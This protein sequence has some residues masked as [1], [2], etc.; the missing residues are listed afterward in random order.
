MSGI[1]AGQRHLSDIETGLHTGFPV[2]RKAKVEAVSE[3]VFAER[4]L[5]LRT[6][7]DKYKEILVINKA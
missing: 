6:T 2:A 4:L 5:P 1:L 7:F 3:A